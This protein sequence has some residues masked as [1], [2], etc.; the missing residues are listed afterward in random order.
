[1]YR[2]VTSYLGRYA[3]GKAPQFYDGFEDLLGRVAPNMLADIQEVQ[4]AYAKY[5]QAEP[6]ERLKTD[7]VRPIPKVGYVATATQRAE[8]QAQVA[9]LQPGDKG[10]KLGFIYSLGRVFT[11]DFY[12]NFVSK[13]FAGH[14]FQQY[15]LNLNEENTAREDLSVAERIQLKMTENGLDA[16]TLSQAI[17]EP[18]ADVQAILA[19]TK[20]PSRK[21]MDKLQAPLGMTRAWIA[22]GRNRITLPRGIDLYAKMKSAGNVRS[23]VEN[24]FNYGFDSRFHNPDGTTA[25]LGPGYME[26]MAAVMNTQGGNYTYDD[27]MLADFDAFLIARRAALTLYPKYRQG[28]LPNQPVRESEA[29]V[30][31]VHADMLAKHPH[32]EQAVEKWDEFHQ[33]WLMYAKEWGL[34]ND[35]QY[36]LYMEDQN[37]APFSRD[38]ADIQIEAGKAGASGKAPTGQLVK[39]LTGSNRNILS[40]TAVTMA[41]IQTL[42]QRAYQQ[43]FAEVLENLHDIAGPGIGIVMEK[44]PATDFKVQQINAME[45]VR[46]AVQAAGLEMDDVQVLMDSLADVAG[47]PEDL[48]LNMFSQ[49]P[50]Q[51]KPGETLIP[52]RKDGDL[53][54]MAL[55]STKAEPHLAEDIFTAY[56]MAGGA[57]NQEVWMKMLQNLAQVRR[58]QI[59][60]W[61]GFIVRNLMLDPIVHWG[62]FRWIKFPGQAHIQGIKS[63]WNQD[64][65]FRAYTSQLAGSGIMGGQLTAMAREG[66]NEQSIRK[67][68]GQKVGT[69]ENI[70]AFWAKL[71]QFSEASE[72]FGRVG[73]FKMAA[74]RSM[75]QQEALGLPVDRIA[76]LQEAGYAAT[77]VMNYAEFGKIMTMFRMIS[78]FFGAG[79]VG[80]DKGIRTSTGYSQRGFAIKRYQEAWTRLGDRNAAWDSLSDN[81]RDAIKGAAATTFKSLM[82]FG[83]LDMLLWA[84]FHDDDDWKDVPDEVHNTHWVVPIGGAVHLVNRDWDEPG[85]LK[86]TMIRVP[87]PFELG[88]PG[89]VVRLSMDAHVRE[90]GGLKTADRIT[91]SMLQSLLPPMSMPFVEEYAALGQNRNPMSDRPLVPNY[92]ATRD[93]EDQAS[94]YTSSI[95]KA[96]GEATLTSPLAV[97]FAIKT[98]LGPWGR[99]LMNL[100]DRMDP[101]KPSADLTSFPLPGLSRFVTAQGKGSVSLDEYYQTMNPAMQMNFNH[102]ARLLGQDITAYNPAKANYHAAFDRGRLDLARDELGKMN[103]QERIFSML[104]ENWKGSDDVPALSPTAHKRLHPLIRFEAQ[105][106]VLL[107]AARDITSNDLFKE[108][109]RIEKKYKPGAVPAIDLNPG[110]RRDV[111]KILKAMQIVEASNALTLMGGKGHTND[112]TVPVEPMVLELKAASPK[113]YEE[114][115]RRLEKANVLPFEAIEKTWPDVHRIMSDPTLPDKVTRTEMPLVKPILMGVYGQADRAA[116]ELK[117]QRE[118]VK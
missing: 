107:E 99:D 59:T 25:K 102:L 10:Q 4:E 27:E 104:S 29:A 88:V 37:Y 95:G 111:L 38:M 96:V 7:I 42:V 78:P 92:L 85:F 55:Y 66:I 17:H 31:K 73:L 93:P 50:I 6:S 118:A 116:R 67:L 40:P 15:A 76:A 91:S 68:V 8:A 103:Q 56:A 21:I 5:A 79:I 105:K 84:L 89:N 74:E 54:F 77:D 109:T 57:P 39:R 70:R 69:W 87:K 61:P 100:T 64:E 101:N 35:E 106:T 47:N 65:Y 36:G 12:R 113:A 51:A 62:L 110:E 13:H 108:K 72:M 3:Q 115:N 97:D 1:M 52:Y 44:V 83:A 63:A 28:I 86:D 30:R 45:A 46:K 22:T 26:V 41:R 11:S 117:K 43:S 19:G 33:S 53:Q 23:W 98:A 18:L 58:A 2:Y 90:Q 94:P 16:D 32:F 9:Q 81:E 49:R 14:Q 20:K 112:K 80:T 71:G 82:V 24:V 75:K 114:I 60:T 48:Q 34:I